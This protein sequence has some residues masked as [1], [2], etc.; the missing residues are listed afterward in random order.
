MITAITDSSSSDGDYTK[1]K[2]DTLVSEVAVEYDE[3]PLKPV[4]LTN[5]EIVR[6]V[7]YSDD[8]PSLNAWTFRSG[9]L[10]VGLGI[11]GSVLA[12]IYYF[13]PQTIEIGRAHV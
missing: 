12:E 10:G 4:E 2:K 1:E 9:L 3:A 13:K 5:E 8:D 6:S 7:L 11:F